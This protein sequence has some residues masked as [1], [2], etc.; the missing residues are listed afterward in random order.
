MPLIKT[1]LPFK[2][3]PMCTQIDLEREEMYAGGHL[4]EI[5][6][7]CR[8]ERIC[9]EVY[10]AQQKAKEQKLLCPADKCPEHAGAG[11]CGEC[12]L[13]PIAACAS[14]CIIS[15]RANCPIPGK[16]FGKERGEPD[17]RG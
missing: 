10:K 13:Y 17:E 11:C 1:K 9:E 8:N 2:W 3:C 6:N 5:S 14:G 7:R 12:L 16:R 15:C 4:A